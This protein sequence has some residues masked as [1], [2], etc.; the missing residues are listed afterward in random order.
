MF[1]ERHFS[2][3]EQVVRKKI[4][5]PRRGDRRIEH[6]HGARGR[7]SRVHKDF[8][9]NPLLLP[10]QRFERFLRHHDFAADFEL[11][12]QFIFL[13]HGRV[14]A[15]RNRTDGFHV[16]RD[17]LAGGAIAAR[18]AAH[19]QAILVLQR[20][21]Q[22]IEFMLGDVFDFLLA[23]SLSHSPIPLSQRIIRKR[24]VQAQHG[25]HVLYICKSFTRRTAHTHGRRV[26]RHQLRMRRLQLFQPVHH[27][28][29]RR[30]RNLR[31]IGHVIEVFVVMQLL[32]QVFDLFFDACRRGLGHE[33]PRF[34]S[35]PFTPTPFASTRFASTGC[36]PRP[37]FR[38]Q[39]EIS[40]STRLQDGVLE[41]GW[42]YI[43]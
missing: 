24:V 2:I 8:A 30:V 18:N 41:F 23:A 4:Q 12:P 37:S 38:A 32:A 42:Y 16:W 31:L 40:L 20:D 27:P 7:I 6:A 28:V 33:T 19:Q 25:P 14:H 5:P 17:V 36:P 35:T 13:Q 11:R 43:E 1:R 3:D 10:V 29:V 15:Q 21:A 22:A 34:A 39:R 26:R 9:A